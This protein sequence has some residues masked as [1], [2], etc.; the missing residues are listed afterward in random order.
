M[1]PSRALTRPVISLNGAQC[2]LSRARRCIATIGPEK[3]K[4]PLAGVRV[5]DMTRVL[6]GVGP[7]A[8]LF[9]YEFILIL[10]SRIARRCWE[11]LGKLKLRYRAIQ[12]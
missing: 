8:I 5:L 2:A 11:I 6:A 7:Q 10:Y 4:G 3:G 9:M 12:S 1:A